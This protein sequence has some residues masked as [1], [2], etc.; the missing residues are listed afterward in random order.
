MSSRPAR[1]GVTEH[2]LGASLYHYARLMRLD[3]PIGIWLLLWPMLWALWIAGE[4]RPQAAVFSIMVIGVV[5][6]R[7]A[8]CVIND[9]ADRDLDPHVER[10]RERPLAA[11]QV[12]PQEALVLFAALSLVAVALVLQLNRLTQLLAVGGAL[13]TVVYPF[14]KRFIS[15]PQLVLGAAF[16]WAVPMAFAAETGAVPRL[17]WLLWL[18]VV[19]WALIYDTMYAMADRA[20]DLR[21][22][23]KST[24][25]LFGSADVFIVSLLMII[26]VLGLALA[27]QLAGLGPWYYGALLVASLL[28]F[29]ERRLIAGREPGA[30]F[31]AFL[32][33]HWVGAVVF[34]GIVLDFTFRPLQA[35]P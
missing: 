22:G 33:S 18:T 29:K 2:P 19:I 6:M 27:G 5:V 13:L 26:L 8:G 12:S 23:V 25:I 20:D 9:W 32:H 14:M 17:A 24:A 11:G 28:L 4:G 34:A 7:S 31:A 30:C 16:G 3:R 1:P 21:V 15:A 10:T 35:I